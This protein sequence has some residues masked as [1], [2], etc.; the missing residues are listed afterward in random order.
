MGTLKKEQKG[1]L[2][3]F[4]SYIFKDPSRWLMLPF[5]RLGFAPWEKD[6]CS[7]GF[8]S[9][10]DAKGRP[11]SAISQKVTLTSSL[12]PSFFSSFLSSNSYLFYFPGGG[13]TNT[14]DLLSS[15]ISS[16][17]YSI[18][19]FVSMLYIRCPRTHLITKSLYPWPASP[20]VLNPPAPSN[21]DATFCFYGLTFLDAVY[22]RYHKV[23]VFLSLAYFA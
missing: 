14:W 10:N 23:F 13:G 7:P 22:K 3:R 9:S 15:Q 5:P 12:P 8:A 4:H 20:H 19:N 18:I 17:H 6:A 1:C 21:H 16:A 11:A 2:T